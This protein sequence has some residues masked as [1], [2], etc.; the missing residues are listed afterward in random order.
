VEIAAIVQSLAGRTFLHD[1]H[2]VSLPE[3]SKYKERP[4]TTLVVLTLETDASS[5]GGKDNI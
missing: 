3:S 5:Y 1:F 2:D 4:F